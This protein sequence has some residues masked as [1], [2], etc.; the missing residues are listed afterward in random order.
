M[1]VQLRGRFSRSSL[2]GMNKKLV[3]KAREPEGPETPERGPGG[4]REGAPAGFLCFHKDIGGGI[5][6]L[7]I[8]LFFF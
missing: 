8:W 1:H 7:E 5:C 6:A 3:L 4:E 2:G